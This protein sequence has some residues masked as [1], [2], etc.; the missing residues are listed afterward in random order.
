VTDLLSLAHDAISAFQHHQPWLAEKIGAAAMAKV[1]AKPNDA[2][3]WELLKGKLL[4]ALDQDE[5]FR[6]TVQELTK[7]TATVQQAIGIGHK[8]VS[9]T[10]S[11]DVKINLH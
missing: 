4:E 1:E 8:Q 5:A 11:K 10:G 6:S 7:S 9:V 2:V 3:Q